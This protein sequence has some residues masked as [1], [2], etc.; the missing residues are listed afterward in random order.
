MAW[1]TC[2][3]VYADMHS[4][5]MMICVLYS[6]YFKDEA[7]AER[8]IA[9]RSTIYIWCSSPGGWRGCR[10][11]PTPPR[12]AAP[13]RA[14]VLRCDVIASMVAEYRRML[15]LVQKY[16]RLPAVPSKLVD[17]VWHEHVLDTQRYQRDCLK[18]FGKYMH[19]APSFGAEDEKA[20]LVKAQEEMLKKYEVEYGEKPT[21]GM[22]P[23]A[24]PNPG[25]GEKMPDCCSFMC[26]KPSCAGCVGCNAVYCGFDGEQDLPKGACC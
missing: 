15:G 10:E 8:A 2:I 5:L 11:S 17:L 23:Q 24:S 1:N 20:E 25:G 12:P 19:H 6:R 21:K 3:A 4:M 16:P 22:W 26:V 9:G 7:T 18:M 14:D 13:T